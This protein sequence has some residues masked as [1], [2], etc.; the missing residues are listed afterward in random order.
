MFRVTPLNRLCH[1]IPK[2]LWLIVDL[3]PG[4]RDRFSTSPVS[5][6]SLDP[7][8]PTFHLLVR[9]CRETPC[10]GLP[11]DVDRTHLQSKHQR[12]HPKPASGTP[13]YTGQEFDVGARLRAANGYRGLEQL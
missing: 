4:T 5:E 12:W 11:I 8:D 1:W 6:S 7:D 9:S 3:I 13:C 2:Q 10:L